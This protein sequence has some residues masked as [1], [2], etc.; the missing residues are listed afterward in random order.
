MEMT[1]ESAFSS[2]GALGHMA[3]FLLVLSMLM[4]RM[5]WLRIL[6]IASAIAGIAYSVLI[7]TDP[8]STFWES[9]LI[10][11][12]IGQLTLS[13]WLDRRTQFDT[14]EDNL[15]QLHFATLAP[16]R[17]RRLLRLGEW[18]TLD[19]GTRL[20]R[21]GALVD[22][23][24]FLHDGSARVEVGGVSIGRCD[25]GSL[26]G[27]MTV[28]SGEPAFADVVLDGP[29]TVWRIDGAVLRDLAA[30]DSE[31]GHAL[32]A[33]FFRMIRK[34]LAENNLRIRAEADIS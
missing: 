12:N 13:W 14:R 18:I 28:A 9:M 21:A 8:V 2:Q 16:N 19:A 22:A 10:T 24:C 11:V 7:L 20:T 29:A 32:E 34:R 27:E 15:R 30:R 5:I 3:Y 6:V 4:R 1:L 17:L 26:I 33:A 23:L 31:I 25:V